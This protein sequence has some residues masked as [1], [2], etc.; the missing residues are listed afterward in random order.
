MTT[1]QA[2]ARRYEIRLQGHLESRWAAWFDGMSL[3]N[4]SDGTTAIRGPVIDQAALHGLLQQTARHRPAADLGHPARP[5]RPTPPP[6][7]P[8]RNAT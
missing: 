2:A 5:D 3:T 1:G 6:P 8:R 4:D 7:T